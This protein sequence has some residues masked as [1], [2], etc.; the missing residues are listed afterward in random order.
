MGPDALTP[1]AE[2]RL[3]HSRKIIFACEGQDTMRIIFSIQTIC[4][5]ILKDVFGVR[6]N[7]I[8]RHGL[9]GT[10]SEDHSANNA[11]RTR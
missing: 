3:I 8:L 9:C 5:E 11:K 2:I 1:F 10:N 4:P 7:C 6:H